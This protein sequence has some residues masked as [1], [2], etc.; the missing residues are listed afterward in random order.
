MRQI[1]PAEP[2]DFNGLESTFDTVL[3]INVLEYLDHPAAA[4]RAMA[5][6][7]KSGGRL[8]TLVPQGPGLYG[9]LDK[10]MGHRRRFAA[11]EVRQ[12]LEENGLAVERVMNFNKIG[13][14]PWRVYSRFLRSNRINKVTLKLFDKTVWLWRRL[15][16]FLPWTGLSLIVVAVKK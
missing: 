11:R 13:A 2:A 8:V 6:S 14:P 12:L 7:L 3:A 10:V 9:T 5:R 1:D 15:D 4:V 16:R